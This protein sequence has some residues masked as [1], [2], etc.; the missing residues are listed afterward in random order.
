MERGEPIPIKQ[1]AQHKQR[2]L[3]KQTKQQAINDNLVR[4]TELGLELPSKK[5]QY[6]L[7][8]KDDYK[9]RV[10]VSRKK[11]NDLI[12]LDSCGTVDLLEIIK[13]LETQ[14]NHNAEPINSI[15]A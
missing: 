4:L 12:E 6:Y 7:D 13:M 3:A 11:T 2:L 1:T 5:R 9:Q 15:I 8:H 14:L 10:K